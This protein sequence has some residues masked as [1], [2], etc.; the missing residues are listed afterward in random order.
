[1]RQLDREQQIIHSRNIIMYWIGFFCWAGTILFNLIGQA[2]I[3]NTVLEFAI[4]S[5]VLLFIGTII[6]K[7]MFIH[8]TMYTVI[9]FC[10]TYVFF[11]LLL[12]PHIM[13]W[14]FVFF[15]TA[16]VQLYLNP[17]AVILNLFITLGET[18][19]LY[20][21]SGHRERIFAFSSPVDGIFIFICLILI[22]C[23]N[24]ATSWYGE[25]MRLASHADKIQAENDKA[26]IEQVLSEKELSQKSAFEFSTRLDVKVT[27]T[28]HGNLLLASSTTQMQSSVNSLSQ[29]IY[30]VSGSIARINNE[31]QEIYDFTSNMLIQAKESGNIIH[32]SEAKIDTL[33]QSMKKQL[34]IMGDMIET[35]SKLE[36]KLVQIEE[37]TKLIDGFAAQT[38]LLSLN[39]AIE[40]ARAGEHG[41]GFAVVADEV[42]KLSEEISGGAKKIKFVKEEIST[43]VIE[44]SSKAHIAME[45]AKMGETSTSDVSDAFQELSSTVHAVVDGNVKVKELVNLL[46]KEQ[47]EITQNIHIIST[48]AE[49]NSMNI[50]EIS[51]LSEKTA[52]T[53]KELQHDFSQ[54]FNQ[55]K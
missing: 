17:K 47:K 21:F 7:R 27:D 43:S 49:E 50:E 12:E 42:K 15:T 28:Q 18:T 33:S 20:Y 38:S 51:S 11:L 54:L 26:I 55:I 5:I 19:Y 32:V 34:L 1:M 8:Y 37:L 16:L 13:T 4:G 14:I 6:R 10:T 53:F 44:A 23:V 2:S 52:S 39:A 31:V 25:K 46:G 40:A 3:G 9:T 22:V 30:D 24:M 29:S 45:F 36:G 41:R 35:N 48:I